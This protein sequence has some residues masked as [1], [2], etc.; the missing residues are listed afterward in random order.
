[1][2]DQVSSDASLFSRVRFWKS[3]RLQAENLFPTDDSLRWFIRKHEQALVASGV[4]LKLPRGTHIDPEPF[5]A[6]AINLMRQ[7]KASTGAAS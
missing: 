5:C 6:A 7:A 3:F 2:V 4:L 1:M